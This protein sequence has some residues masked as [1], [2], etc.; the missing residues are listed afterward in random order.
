MTNAPMPIVA[1]PTIT[2]MAIPPKKVMNPE[3]EHGAGGR[4]GRFIEKAQDMMQ[5]AEQILSRSRR[6]LA[7]QGQKHL[8]SVH[9][10][11]A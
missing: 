10:G 11:T 4:T 7:A 1:A 5:R 2:M 8:A 6:G 9:D 3:S